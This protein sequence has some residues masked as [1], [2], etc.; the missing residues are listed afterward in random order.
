[1]T[2]ARRPEWV[3]AARWRELAEA[4]GWDTTDPDV[5]EFVREAEYRDQDLENHLAELS[6]PGLP[7]FTWSG[8]LALST[9]PPWTPPVTVFVSEVRV[10]L[11]TAGSSTSTVE[12][13]KNGTMF[14]EVDMTSSTTDSGKVETSEFFEPGD[15]LTCEITA[16]GTGAA[17]LTVV[18]A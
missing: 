17:D 2:E 6:G 14:E 1:M 12:I 7:P 8:G 5:M 18:L 13:Q 9:S 10:L 15:L 16:V 4:L 11:G 3:Y